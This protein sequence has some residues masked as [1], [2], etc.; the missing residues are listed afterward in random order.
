MMK[1]VHKKNEPKYCPNTLLYMKMKQRKKTSNSKRKHL[2]I[3]HADKKSQRK[4]SLN[5]IWKMKRKQRNKN[6]L[7]CPE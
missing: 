4:Y 5:S 2:T 7:I 1:D 3:K 6:S